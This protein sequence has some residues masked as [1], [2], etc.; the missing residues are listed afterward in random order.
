MGFLDD[1]F[2]VDHRRRGGRQWDDDD[3]D[4]DDHRPRRDEGPWTTGPSQ[5]AD[6]SPVP[7]TLC[8]KCSVPVG[9]MPGFCFCPYCG[10]GLNVERTCRSCSAKLAAGAA[11]CHSCGTRL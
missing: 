11:F 10:T 5:A 7:T 6:R 8:P 3:H 9:M 2:D 4:H 1:L